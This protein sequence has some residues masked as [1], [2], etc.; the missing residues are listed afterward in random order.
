MPDTSF[1]N[2]LSIEMK[3]SLRIFLPNRGCNILPAVSL[4]PKAL[5][6]AE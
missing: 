6:H 5:C 4:T 2:G 3:T 1:G